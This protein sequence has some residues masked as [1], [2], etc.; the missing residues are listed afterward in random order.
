MSNPPSD[1]SDRT[2]QNTSR[3]A[4]GG[5]D[6]RWVEPGDDD[7]PGS[8]ALDPG[9]APPPRGGS[10]RMVQVVALAGVAIVA[11]AAALLYRTHHRREVLSQGMAR[12]RELMRTD[13]WAGYRGASQILEPLV[14]IDA[15]EAGELRA[16]ALAMLAA[17]YRDEP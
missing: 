17:D 14:A 15:M 3:G 5:R 4:P 11:L 2:D 13:T 6:P 1:P 10:S 9:S 7:G 16:Q 8:T 12:A